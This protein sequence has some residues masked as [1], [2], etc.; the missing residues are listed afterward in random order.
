[1]SL[2]NYNDTSE[3]RRRRGKGHAMYNVRIPDALLC[4]LLGSIY[5]L[6][7]MIRREPTTVPAAHIEVRSLNHTSA[8]SFV[9]YQ[10]ATFLRLI[11]HTHL[12]KTSIR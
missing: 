2:R 8:S 11:I 3:K 6:Y 5:I 12:S 9:M 10:F 7:L 1:M 4:N